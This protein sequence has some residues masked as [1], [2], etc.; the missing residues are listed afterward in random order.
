MQDGLAV[1][2]SMYARR[3]LEDPY[4]RLM[5]TSVGEKLKNLN[6]PT[7]LGIEAA[8]NL[9]AAWKS[10]SET[11]LTDTPWKKFAYEVIMDAPSELNKRILNGSKNKGRRGPVSNE[12]K[13]ALDAL[14]RLDS[15]TT[16]ALLEWIS[17][18]GDD[19][20]EKL[21]DYLANL[22]PNV[23]AEAGKHVQGKAT[24]REPQACPPAKMAGESPSLL[25]DLAKNLNRLSEKLEQRRKP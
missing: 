13:A 25:A 22:V 15:H 23:K 11:S 9:L 17:T 24:A 18:A 10:Q 3:L 4:D 7:Q 19:E 5:S 14:R 1:F 20:R 6:R 12:E 8:V 16:N 21:V 2:G